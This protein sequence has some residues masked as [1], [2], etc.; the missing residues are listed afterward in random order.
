[1]VGVDKRRNGVNRF[2]CYMMND[3]VM[4]TMKTE[5]SKYN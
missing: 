3:P 5:I 4:K 1:M 2:L